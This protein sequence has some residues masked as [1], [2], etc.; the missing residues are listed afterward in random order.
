MP[1]KC[2]GYK[3][4]CRLTL[5]IVGNN[6]LLFG[7][8]AVCACLLGFVQ[9][10]SAQTTYQ[11]AESALQSG[12]YPLAASLFE[13]A[14]AG[15]TSQAGQAKYLAAVARYRNGDY[16]QASKILSNIERMTPPLPYASQA[17]ELQGASLLHQRKWLAGS[18]RLAPKGMESQKALATLLQGCPPDTLV[19]LANLYPAS[20]GIKA[21]LGAGKLSQST[22]QPTTT[23]NP[24]GEVRIGLVLPLSLP[25]D[26][27]SDFKTGQ[28]MA[29]FCVAARLAETDA[30]AAG[31]P[32][33]LYFY[34]SYRSSDTITRLIA[35]ADLAQMD[36]LI[37]PIYSKETETLAR[38]AN[39]RRVPM[40]NPLTN[41]VHFDTA[42]TYAYLAEPGLA[43][44][45]A[46]A[47]ALRAPYPGQRVGCIYGNSMQDSVLA[48]EFSK[49]AKKAGCIMALY[50][51]VAKNSAANLPKFIT[52]A[53]FDSTSILFVPNSEPLV[54]AQ[55]LS[56]LEITRTPALPVTYGNWIEESEIPLERFER[57]H[58]RFLYPDFPGF[59]Q[60]VAERLRTRI[61]QAY[62]LPATDVG[63][64]AYDLVRT[65]GHA[66]AKAKPGARGS[67]LKDY[68][69]LHSDLSAGYDYTLGQTN[70]RVP[71]YRLFDG[72]LERQ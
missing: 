67:F 44:M 63:L 8:A 6:V 49:A 22:L 54:K 17:E 31:D 21:R 20:E 62:G 34:D 24:I 18:R 66:L 37:G 64:K 27:S 55:L 57:L 15:T 69:P 5:P 35:G 42:G 16:V 39:E 53:D 23:P 12:Q 56:A 43:D 1:A 29:E 40:V 32:V 72:K 7:Y 36:L 38:F 30:Q 46:A 33:H 47:L 10:A 14:G 71:I 13:Q 68:S 65:L 11:R 3:G 26:L 45:A 59:G 48:V 51:N 50:K 61:F 4:Y 25:K 58:I 41:L 60:P 9:T 2:W 28:K 52:E 19:K 70:A